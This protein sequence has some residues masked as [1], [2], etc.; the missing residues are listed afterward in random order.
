MP[1]ENDCVNDALKS[2]VIVAAHL[3]VGAFGFYDSMVSPF[4]CLFLSVSLS[5]FFP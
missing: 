2:F 4:F 1:L 3:I 5:L